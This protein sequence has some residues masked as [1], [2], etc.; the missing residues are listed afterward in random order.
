[1]RVV[2]EDFGDKVKA[3]GAVQIK[4]KKPDPQV[5]LLEKMVSEVKKINQAGNK[6]AVPPVNIID[7]PKQPAP[8][9]KVQIDGAKEWEFTV[10][11]RRNGRIHKFKAKRLA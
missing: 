11:E 8:V 7:V 10:T 9:V 4:S 2:E 6:E 5:T 3:K 1:M